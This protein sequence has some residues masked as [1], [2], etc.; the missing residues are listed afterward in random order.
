VISSQLHTKSGRDSVRG[1][2]RVL[3]LIPAF[4]VL[5]AGCGLSNA[6]SGRAIN[7]VTAA[8]DGLAALKEKDWAKADAELTVALDAKVLSGDQY[9]EALLGR[10]RARLETDNLVG[11]DHDINTLEEGAAAQ[12]QV[13]ALKAELLLKQGDAEEAKKTFQEAKKLNAKL[14]VP[15]GL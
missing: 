5:F 11:A 9:E 2:F 12:D 7:A 3:V 14:P 8:A 15:A 13:L 6:P 10:A 1:L 4:V